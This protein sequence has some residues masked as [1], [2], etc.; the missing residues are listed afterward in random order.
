M[1][2]HSS[3]LAWRSHGQSSLAGYSPR[4]RKESDSTEPLHFTSLFSSQPQYLVVVLVN[5]HCIINCPKVQRFKPTIYSVLLVCRW[6]EKWLS[7]PG[8]SPG[9]GMVE[10]KYVSVFLV[11]LGTACR[12]RWVIFYKDGRGA[13]GQARVCKHVASLLAK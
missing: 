13:G 8:W 11:F 7:R 9:W 6:A 3:V 4:G 12:T 2:T 1:A 10:S 5:Y